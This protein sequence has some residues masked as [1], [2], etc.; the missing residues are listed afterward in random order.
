MEQSHMEQPQSVVIQTPAPN[1]NDRIT[2]LIGIGKALAGGVMD[3]YAHL[4]P[5]GL[6]TSNPTFWIGLVIAALWGLQG[7]F[8]NRGGSS[9][10]AQPVGQNPSVKVDVKS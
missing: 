10:V 6:D 3:Y 8:T 4:G 1:R 7:Y 5:D 2:T 9:I